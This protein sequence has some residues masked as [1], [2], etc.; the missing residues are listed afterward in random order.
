MK[1]VYSVYTYTFDE[2]VCSVHTN[3]V[4]EVMAF[5]CAEGFCLLQEGEL[6]GLLN[7]YENGEYSFASILLASGMS[8]KQFAAFMKKHKI[9]LRVN[10]N[11]IDKGK[12][13]SEDAL[14]SVL[15]MNENE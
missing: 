3:I 11:F 10:F 15:E 4:L 6:L 7:A 8:V 2:V 5:L 1:W 14:R 12:G 13:L 9:E